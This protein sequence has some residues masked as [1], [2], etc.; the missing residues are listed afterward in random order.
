MPNNQTALV[1]LVVDSG[2]D[3]VIL[4]LKLFGSAYF[5]ASV[6]LMTSSPAVRLNVFTNA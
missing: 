2:K 6:V 3:I 1:K 5:V 4:T